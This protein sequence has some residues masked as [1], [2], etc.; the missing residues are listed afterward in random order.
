VK[1]DPAG[2]TVLAEVDGQALAAGVLLPRGTAVDV[3]FAVPAP[4]ASVAP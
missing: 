3:T 4:P 2:V 1:G